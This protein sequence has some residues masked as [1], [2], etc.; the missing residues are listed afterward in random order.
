FLERD[1]R[2]HIF[3][4]D[5][6]ARLA[7]SVLQRCERDVQHERAV[8]TRRGVELVDVANL[9]E[10]PTVFA[11]DLFERVG[12]VFREQVLDTTANCRIAT[13]IENVFERRVQARDTSFQV[14][15]QQS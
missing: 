5:E 3:E 6:R 10:A 7:L 1:A 15:R 4:H 13:Q 11:Q 8:T 14:D 9:F 2:G 12:K